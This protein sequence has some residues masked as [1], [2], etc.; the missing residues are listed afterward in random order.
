[1]ILLHGYGL[2][3]QANF[4]PFDHSRPML[5][6][7]LALFRDEMGYA[8]PMPTPPIEGRRGLA[9]FL[10]A[11]GARVIVPDMRGFGDSGKHDDPAAYSDSAMA[12]D[13]V[14]L[15][16]HLDLD[17]VDVCGFSMGAL[18]AAKLLALGPVSVK[19]AILAGIGDYILEGEVMDLPEQWP[20]P[21]HLPRPITLPVHAREG[22]RLLEGGT[23]ERGN[24]MA[25]QVLMARA[26]AADPRVL[27]AVL[28]GTMAEQV[29][30]TALARAAPV[31]VLN[32]QSDV[33]NHA[34]RRLLAV[35]PQASAAVCAGDH[36]STPFEPSFQHAVADF[37]TAQRQAREPTSQ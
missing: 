27:A 17:G 8:P 1:V 12:R 5:E 35:M 4:G 18:V 9:A 30:P 26:T 25:A 2:D 32:G 37:F 20:L 14:A 29:P 15:I 7:T 28:R 6:R 3:G 23:I 36:G 31:L 16:A 21:D 13:V 24:V 33:A 22:A 11:G 10:R 34:T 19:S